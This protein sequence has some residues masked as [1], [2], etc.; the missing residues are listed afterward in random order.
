M[1]FSAA[2]APKPLPWL[3]LQTPLRR[4]R[5]IPPTAPPPLP[6]PPPPP[7]PPPPPSPPQLL[8]T[9]RRPLFVLFATHAETQTARSHTR[10]HYMRFTC[11]RGCV[12]ALERQCAGFVRVYARKRVRVWAL[13]R[14]GGVGVW[15][16]TAPNRGFYYC[17]RA[18]SRS[19]TR[20]PPTA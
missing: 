18:A 2:A 13:A 1:K 8:Y 15:P 20:R 9:R 7:I 3:R 11:R 5:S 16:I 17:H 12:R 19:A 14:M 10:A 4:R 6:P